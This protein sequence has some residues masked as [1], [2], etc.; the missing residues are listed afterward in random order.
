[1]EKVFA[2]TFTNTANAAVVTVIDA[3]VRVVVPQLA[4]VAIVAGSRLAALGAYIAGTLR[5]TAEHAQH[6]LGIAARQR[7]LFRIVVAQP[8]GIPALACE[9]LQLHVPA[10]VLTAQ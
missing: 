6:V 9:A 1:M 3:L 4:D 10:V 7:V 2:Q 5:M 8:A